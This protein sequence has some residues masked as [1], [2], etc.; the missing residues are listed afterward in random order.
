M[1]EEAVRE[2]ARMMAMEPYP[3]YEGKYFSMP[4]RNVVPK[5]VQ[6]PH[7]PLWVACS[8][9]DTIKLAARARHR[10]AHLR[11]HRPGGR[12]VLGRGVLRDVQA[13]VHADRPRREPEHRDGDRLHVPRG[14]GATAV[15]AGA[16]GL[17]VLRLRARPLLHHRDPR[18]RAPQRLGRVQEGAALPARCRRAA[19]ATRT[20][21]APTSR[22]SRRWASTR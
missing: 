12:Q 20:R 19:S 7:P 4:P 8:N 6:K 9:R 3:G 21:C 10:R 2:T 1:W 17:Q 5:P 16:R 14:L 18:A 22:S 13:R 11:L 15:R